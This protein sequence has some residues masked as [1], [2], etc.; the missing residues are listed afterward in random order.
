MMVSVWQAAH[1]DRL[2]TAKYAPI[3]TFFMVYPLNKIVAEPTWM[4]QEI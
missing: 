4:L 2:E 1:N 3:M